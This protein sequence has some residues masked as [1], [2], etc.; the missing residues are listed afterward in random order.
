MARKVGQG[1]EEEE[2][3]ARQR[4]SV[5]ARHEEDKRSYHTLLSCMDAMT[6]DGGLKKPSDALEMELQTVVI[7][8]A[9]LN[10]SAVE[11]QLTPFTTAITSTYI[12]VKR[13]DV[14]KERF[15]Q[16]VGKML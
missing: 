16:R 10:L 8:Y 15:E 12:Y 9:V 5:A 3:R 7:H 13:R 4:E 6:M 1:K 2:S 14:T 11:K